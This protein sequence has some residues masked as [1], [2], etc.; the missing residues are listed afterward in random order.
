MNIFYFI[1]IALAVYFS[2][3]Y[4]W[5]EEYDRHKQH[6]LWLLCF[7]LICLSGFSYGLGGDKFTYMN[8]FEGYPDTFSEVGNFVWYNVMLRGQMPLWTLV[9]L[10][11]KSVFHS[12]YALQFIQSTAVNISVCYIVSKYT[13]RYF[14]FLLIY[15]FSLKFFVFNTEIMREGFA[16]SF[17]LIGLHGWMSGK[18]W[19]YFLTVPIGFMLHVSALT[20]LLFPFMKFHVSWKTLLYA[21]IISFFLWGVSDIV[22]GTVMVS[23]LG[24]MGAFVQKVLFYSIQA[25]SIF[26]FIRSVVTYLVFPF[27]IMYSVML[28]EPSHAMRQ[29]QEKIIS[30][31]VVLAIL[32]SSFA[33][34]V[35]LYNASMIFYLVMLS[36]FVYSLFNYRK[37]LIVR[38]CTLVGTLLLTLLTYRIHYKTTDTYYYDFFFPY[39]CILDED[40]NVYIR[41]AAHREAVAGEEK[42]NNV[43]NVE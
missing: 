19:L 29:R 24:G 31:M 8:E 2:F 17:V 30:F 28:N 9:N 40:K 41:D 7:Y 33:G 38:L 32:A 14:L 26:G 23:V 18:K 13:H 12:F 25:S 11:C 34:F 1:F 6:R 3:R 21:V 39:T 20:A 35:R 43:R 37:L 5:I 15:F 16:L 27:I 22:L 42:D 4:D 36:E 10:A